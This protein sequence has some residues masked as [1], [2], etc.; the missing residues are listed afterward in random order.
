MRLRHRV[1]RRG[2]GSDQPAV[3]RR[4]TAPAEGA[5]VELDRLAVQ[6]DSPVERFRRNRHQTTLVGKAEHEEI[7]RQQKS[8]SSPVCQTPSHRGIP[9][10]PG[11]P[12]SRHALRIAH[13]PGRRCR[14]CGWQ[15]ASDRLV[16]VDDRMAAV[17]RPQPRRCFA[18]RRHDEVAAEQQTRAVAIDAMRTAWIAS[19]CAATRTW[20]SSTAPPFLRH[21]D[22]VEHGDALAFEMR[23]HSEQGRRSSRRRCA[24]DAGDENAVGL[25]R[26]AR[27]GQG[28]GRAGKLSAWQP[29]SPVAAL[30]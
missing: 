28:S 4:A 24:A 17:A 16:A 30:A 12:R 26:R 11:R 1:R 2:A 6:F 18:A 10:P 7:G 22:L 14:G 27:A 25:R 8:P 19:G 20:L 9:C 23:G 13:A 3:D 15:I 21:A 5:A 29:L